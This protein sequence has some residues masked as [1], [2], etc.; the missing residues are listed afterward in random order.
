MAK[1]KGKKMAVESPDSDD[2]WRAESDMNTLASAL[3]IKADP[4]RLAAAK[5]CAQCKLDAMKKVTKGG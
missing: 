3:E 1:S 4:K 5:G 2:K